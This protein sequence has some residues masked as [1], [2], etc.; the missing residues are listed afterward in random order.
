MRP[1]AVILDSAVLWH[2]LE[3]SPKLEGNDQLLEFNIKHQLVLLKS[4]SG[5]EVMVLGG[6]ED[7][8]TAQQFQNKVCLGERGS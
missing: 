5:E 4:T 7:W 3:F 8:I 6:K 2:L 1:L